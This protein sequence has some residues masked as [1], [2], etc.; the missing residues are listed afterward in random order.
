M[1]QEKKVK[2]T[3]WQRDS[4]YKDYPYRADVKMAGVTARH[5]PYT[6]FRQQEAESGNYADICETHNGGVYLYAKDLP[7]E[8]IMVKVSIFK[9]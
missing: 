3:D 6:E 2:R 5:F 1:T 8:D 9:E 7:E 4:H